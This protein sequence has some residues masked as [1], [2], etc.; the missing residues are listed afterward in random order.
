MNVRRTIKGLYWL[1]AV[2]LVVMLLSLSGGLAVALKWGMWQIA[3]WSALGVF[4]SYI[5]KRS[6]QRGIKALDELPP[7][8][9]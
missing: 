5:G 2:S 4:F 9:D 1:Y 8:P 3:I 7:D 6:C